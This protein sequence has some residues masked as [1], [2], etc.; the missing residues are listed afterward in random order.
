MARL[1]LLDDARSNLG[2][3]GD[4]R[5]SFEQRTG[6]HTALERA[7]RVVGEPASLHLPGDR[8]ELA[9]ERTSRALADP[10]D[11]S[12]A[13]VVNGRLC[14]GGGFDLPGPGSVHTTSDGTFG[15]ARLAGD[16]LHALLSGTLPTEGC[17]VDANLACFVHPWDII[18]DLGARI[19]GDITLERGDGSVP[20]NVHVVGS[21]DCVIAASATLLPGVVLDASEGP[22]FIGENTTVRAHAV[23]RGPCA[24]GSGCVITD[25]ALLKQGTSI[26]PGC[27]VGGEVGSTVMQARSNKSHAGHLGDSL[28]GEW[29]NIGAGTDNSNLLN[30]HGEVAMRLD[31]EGERHD[32]GRTFMGCVIGDHAKL[33]IGTRIMTGSV[34][35]TGSMIVRATPPTS[36][37]PFSW[38]VGETEEVYRLE[39]FLAMVKAV[40][41]RRNV[42]PGSAYLARLEALHAATSSMMS[43]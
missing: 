26:G 14:S 5:A 16:A 39:S 9:V 20:G 3:L 18:N 32:T 29:V 42:A 13:I 17:T 43:T 10:G 37:A 25:H 15:V 1:I 4:L 41:A 36:V 35:G 22:I 30:T 33:A 19:A 7:E 40:M 12:E 21:F 28:L 6:L 23:L 11:D 27:K 2:P 38:L 31:P 8:A 24:I 34:Y